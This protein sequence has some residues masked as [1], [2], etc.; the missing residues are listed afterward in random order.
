M[1]LG[2][3]QAKGQVGSTVASF[4]CV[5]IVLSRVSIKLPEVERNTGPSDNLLVSEWD[6]HS[7]LFRY[8]LGISSYFSALDGK[9]KREMGW[10][11]KTRLSEIYVGRYVETGA[12]TGRHQYLVLQVNKYRL[13]QIWKG[14]K[15]FLG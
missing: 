1:K 14:Q 11:G 8:D 2:Q 13:E 9:K 15:E 5:Q 4:I 7:F 12:A 6:C 10:G 3:N